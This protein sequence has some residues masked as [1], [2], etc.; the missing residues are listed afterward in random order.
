MFVMIFL[1]LISIL[2][3]SKTDL[4]LNLWML[5]DHLFFSLRHKNLEVQYKICENIFNDISNC[6]NCLN[7]ITRLI[8]KLGSYQIVQT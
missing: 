2:K 5:I 1:Y 6:Y 8:R 7:K 4:K 3:L